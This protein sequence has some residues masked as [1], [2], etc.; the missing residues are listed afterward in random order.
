MTAH[1]D[2][3][4][5]HILVSARYFYKASSLSKTE[6]LWPAIGAYEDT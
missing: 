2:N 6:M 5:D 1:L 3:N 4:D